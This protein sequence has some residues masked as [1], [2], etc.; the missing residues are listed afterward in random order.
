MAAARSPC[1]CCVRPSPS[2]RLLVPGVLLQHLAVRARRAGVVLLHQQSAADGQV[3][4]VE[5]RRHR[6]DVPVL[7]DRL[8]PFLLHH[9]RFGGA[10]HGLQPLRVDAS[11]AP[12]TGVPTSTN[13]TTGLFVPSAT[14]TATVDD[15]KPGALAVNLPEAAAHAQDRPVALLIGGRRELARDDATGLTARTVAR[16]DGLAGDVL[17]RAGQPA[18]RQLR[19]RRRRQRKSGQAGRHGCQDEAGESASLELLPGS[20]L[21]YHPQPTPGRHTCAAIQW[22]RFQDLVLAAS[23]HREDGS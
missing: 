6:Q 15:S 18:D 17:H 23:P 2:E 14:R 9:Q 22:R 13:W 4:R 19:G 11:M 12:L 20:V 8:V 21:A 1:S 16:L 10:Q 5:R 7:G 3:H